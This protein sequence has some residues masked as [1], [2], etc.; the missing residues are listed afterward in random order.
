[1][2]AVPLSTLFAGLVVEWVGLRETGVALAVAWCGV[3]LLLLAV[4]ALRHLD[5]A[6]AATPDSSPRLAQPSGVPH[7]ASPPDPEQAAHRTD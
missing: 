1:M 2:T 6:T 3:S 4:P 5:T 7:P